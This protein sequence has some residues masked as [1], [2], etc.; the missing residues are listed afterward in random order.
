MQLTYDMI[1]DILDV[2]DIA[3]STNG[4]TLP[5][6]VYEVSDITSMI[7]SIHPNEKTV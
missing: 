4:Y 1:V 6:G 2:Q 5:V 7:K 3:G